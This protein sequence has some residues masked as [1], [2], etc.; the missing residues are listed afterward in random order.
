MA[1]GLFVN[2]TLGVSMTTFSIQRGFFNIKSGNQHFQMFMPDE[3]NRPNLPPV[4]D[5]YEWMRTRGYSSEKIIRRLIDRY[6]PFRLVKGNHLL[7]RTMVTGLIGARGSGKSCSASEIVLFDYLIRGWKVWSNM[8]IKATFRYRDAEVTYSTLDVD[9]IDIFTLDLGL[10]HGC[11]YLDE[12]N[13]EFAE[14]R[15]SISNR[16]LKFTNMLQQLRHRQLDLVYSTQLDTFLDTRLRWQTDLYCICRDAALSPEGREYGAKVGNFTFLDVYDYSG[17]YNGYTYT[18][19]DPTLW[20]GIL[21]IKPFW[22][23]YDTFQMQGM[24]G[25]PDISIQIKETERLKLLKEQRGQAE[26]LINY[27]KEKEVMSIP[28]KDLWEVAGIDP[29]DKSATTKLGIQLAA[30]GV[31]TAQGTGGQR[32]Y[33]LP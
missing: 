33:I 25:G 22:H 11:I 5:A 1:L 12:I 24:D 9:K 32:T 19:G 10:Q 7:H 16:N 28:A 17:V 13:L 26:A 29:V 30:L 15:R 14:A 21:W 8:Q 27:L 20:S 18:R 2:A 4:K 31:E 23:V 6:M 3:F